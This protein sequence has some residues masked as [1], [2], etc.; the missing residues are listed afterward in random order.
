[1][2]RSNQRLPEIELDADGQN[3]HCRADDA[4]SRVIG[5]TGSRVCIS[6]ELQGSL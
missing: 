4:R 3:P 6:R 1:M 2:H 5:P